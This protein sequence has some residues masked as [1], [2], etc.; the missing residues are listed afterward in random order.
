MKFLILFLLLLFATPSTHAQP[1]GF[2]QA[3]DLP[4][5]PAGGKFL[6][7]Y[8]HTGRSYFI[9]ISDTDNPLGKWR[10]APIIESGNEQ[11]ISYEVDGTPAKGF[12]R[13]KYTNLP[14]PLGETLETADFD[15][16]GL[17]N[18]DEISPLD[19]ALFGQTDPLN[20]DTDSDGL[21][22]G[23]ERDHGLD[24][25]DDGGIH[26]DN[27]ASGAP[28]AVES[29]I[30]RNSPIRPPRTMGPTSRPNGSGSTT[31]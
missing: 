26:P 1:P 14:I 28:M 4:I 20:G 19:G 6:R 8:G 25:N 9:Q 24:P 27:G 17:S 31:G 7:W 21:P 18:L 29:R 30:P 5:V 13:F 11:Q 3:S 22:D 2:E 16:D 23:W 10:W 12:F 15:G